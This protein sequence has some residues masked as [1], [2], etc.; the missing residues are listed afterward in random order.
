MGNLVNIG[1][2][3][4]VLRRTASI[5]FYLITHAKVISLFHLLETMEGIKVP[6]KVIFS[7]PG[8]DMT[9]ADIAPNGLLLHDQLLAQGPPVTRPASQASLLLVHGPRCSLLAT[10]GVMQEVGGVGV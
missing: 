8:K 6:F 1:D 9:L 10:V 7:P 3:S 5:I 2:R 4:K